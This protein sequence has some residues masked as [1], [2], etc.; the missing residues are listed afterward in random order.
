MLELKRIHI[1][2]FKSFCD[3]T[4]VS[5]DS[6]GVT[7]IVGPNGCGKSN[8][9]D[10]I[11][12]VLG[13]QSAKSLRGVKME[14][15]IFAGTRE[16]KPTGMA[17]VTLVLID[18]E[19][20][21]PAGHSH[22]GPEI[23]ED[24][25][26]EA[27]A[28]SQAAQETEA[29]IADLQPG[30]VIEEADTDGAP[31]ET[32]AT[33]NA[34]DADAVVLKVRRRKFLRNHAQNGE[35]IISRRLFRTGDSEYL[36]NGKLCRLRDIHDVLM[37]TGL[38]A[39]SYGII[40]QE[41]IGQLL[42]SKPHDRRAIIEEAAGITR[43]KTKKHLAE[44]RLEQAK[45]NLARVNDIF[46][47]VA[48]QMN[49]LKRQ[50]AK[51]ER[52]G[53]L[54]DE[55][56]QRLR[57]VIAT[58]L[59]QMDAS[60][61]A[62]AEELS[63][64]TAQIDELTQTIATVDQQR[65]AAVAEG[66]TREQEARDAAAR[67]NASSVELERTLAQLQANQ[68]RAADL[69]IRLQA[70]RVELDQTQ[71]Q[72]NSVEAERSQQ[73]A[74]LAEAE[75]AVDAA[76]RDMQAR[77]EAAHKATTE[78]AATDDRIE[79]ARRQMLHWMNQANQV[80]NQITQGEASL[81][82][83]DREAE[84]LASERSTVHS[85]ME[86]LGVERGQVSLTFESASS[87]LQSTEA[88]L[89]SLRSELERQRAEES[90]SRRQADQLRAEQ[91]T[92]QGRHNSLDALIR[93]HSY[94][95]DTV[96]KLLRTNATESGHAPVGV[97][98]D[99]LEVSGQ[100]E[101]VV[102]EFLRDELNY[103]VVKSWN[104]AQEGMR[105]LKTDV[106]GR[107]TFLVHPDDSQAKFSFAPGTIQP[108]SE[109]RDGVV[110]LK[111]CI[112]V[113]D[114]FGSSLEVILPKLR[115]GY[116]VPDSETARSLAL[117]NPEAF[118]LAPNGECFHNVTV[119]GGKPSVEGPL[120][121]KRELRSAQQALAQTDEALAL[122]DLR[123][124]EL[125]RATTELA[126]QIET[127][128]AE[129]RKAEQESANT[130]A[131]LRQ[132]EA[133]VSRLERRLNEWTLQAERNK[134]THSEKSAWVAQRREEV[135][136]H[137]QQ[138]VQFERQLNESQGSLEA[139]RQARDAAQQQLSHASIELAGL[140]ERR[141]GAANSAERLD[142]MVQGLQ[143]RVQQLEQQIVSGDAEQQQRVVEHERLQLRSQELEATRDLARKQA[144]ELAQQTAALRQQAAKVE[145]QVRA[146][147]VD[148]EALRDRRSEAG[149]RAARLS[150]DL[151]HLEETCMQELSIAPAELR[152]DES[153]VRLEAEPLAIE[154]E[155]CRG[156]K[157]KLESMGPVNMMALD[158]YKEAAERHEFL[159]AQRKD[160]IDSIDNTQ[161]SIR[162]IEAVLRSKFEEAFNA[163]NENF[164]ATFTHL[165]GGGQAFMKLTDQE[166][167]DE[168]GIDIIASPPGK[169]LQN[170]LLLSGG[171]KALTALSLLMA[172][173]QFQPS[174]FC[175]LDEVDAALD[176]SNVGRL[177]HMLQ[178]MSDRTHFIVIT[179]SKR[180][181]Q[182]ADAIF[183]VTMQEAGVSKIVSVRL[184]RDHSLAKA[185]A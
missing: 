146:L 65:A 145:Q 121:L 22:P 24:D 144:E 162:E 26:D 149:T 184:G 60:S 172:I 140:E 104:D 130:G 93:E 126:Q 120:A 68:D 179:H 84:R 1:L 41:R 55:L 31:E 178:K 152:A 3:R 98:A 119:T 35:V 113:L 176:E 77:Q 125:T 147:R 138:R 52:Y 91:A 47:E 12:W 159:E 92:L 34:T 154:E 9:S 163:I 2:G 30:Q 109:S 32:A 166:N 139:L 170:V 43:F 69:A 23:V 54:R 183:G 133:E 168:S 17:E 181:M 131:A 36:L 6:R 169:K 56:R 87:F 10:A 44:L 180:M 153:L 103:I 95:T 112:R 70:A 4:E 128:S 37:G 185:S 42:S 67:A 78:L 164:S 157:Q 16:R 167:S 48:R 177:A 101:N 64:L 57:V 82:A 27:A 62:V 76:Q 51:A 160:L 61:V 151:A 122:A 8:I 40:E 173:F 107:A 74:F 175:V 33:E 29:T 99:F 46:D 73:Q 137:E 148:L 58:R 28:R 174:P 86:K 136:A 5:L 111:D 143:Q 129:R 25:W 158:E 21:Q 53:A 15:V 81:E 80:R 63:Q 89:S 117:E 90:T 155:G 18:P 132:L 7:A 94:S 75:Q 79:T 124:A 19:V 134:Q 97:L 71:Q 123:T 171:E 116:V 102:D 14:D 135:E 38:G 100:Y 66:Y 50:A 115:H 118:F 127:K 105:V 39:E 106:D 59:T 83:L 88:E 85:E 49:S 11:S 182:A 150:S 96:R 72:L 165:F 161:N 20:Y 108:L 45:Q 142:R 141:R 114:G 156:I 110:R 13:E